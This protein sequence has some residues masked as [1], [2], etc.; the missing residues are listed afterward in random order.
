MQYS[1]DNLQFEARQ[2]NRRSFSVGFSLE[3]IVVE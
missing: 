3:E 1:F 2:L